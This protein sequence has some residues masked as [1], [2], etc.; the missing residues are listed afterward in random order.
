MIRTKNFDLNGNT[1]EA[2]VFNRVDSISN[3]KMY[4]GSALHG[5]TAYC[6]FESNEKVYAVH[7][8][9]VYYQV[10]DSVSDEDFNKI[11]ALTK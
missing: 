6:L 9:G 1:Y 5:G 3:P 11:L 7:F 2:I 10:K 8:E 4:I